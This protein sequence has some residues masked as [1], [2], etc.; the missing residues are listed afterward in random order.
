MIG[1]HKRHWAVRLLGD[2]VDDESTISHQGHVEIDYDMN[3]GFTQPLWLC[4]DTRRFIEY[5]CR[6]TGVL[7]EP[8]EP[9]DRH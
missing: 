4:I 6:E 9:S 7:V 1:P 8:E 3:R 5:A 2:S